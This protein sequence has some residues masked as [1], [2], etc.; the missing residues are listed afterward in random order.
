MV[1]PPVRN[2]GTSVHPGRTSETARSLAK[3]SFIPNT[4]KVAEAR[5][6]G[7]RNRIGL[8]LAATAVVVGVWFGVG[9][10][11]SR[12]T[13]NRQ[14]EN[15]CIGVLQAQAAIG[16][17]ATGQPM[18]SIAVLMK[19]F[20]NV[21]VAGSQADFFLRWLAAETAAASGDSPFHLRT[22]AVRAQGLTVTRGAQY[23]TVSFRFTITRRF[24]PQGTS[25]TSGAA[26]F[27]VVHAGSQWRVQAMS[28]NYSPVHQPTQPNSLNPDV[29][30]LYPAPPAPL[31][32]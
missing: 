17:T 15:L 10:A 28:L 4:E 31:G 26:T 20:Q 1:H 25:T 30:H 3:R 21:V 29:W 9:W 6:W 11:V 23:D 32:Q 27:W 2:N 19:P 12:Q 24:A 8:G 14:L 16:K 22:A 5:K 7:T 13:V 18:P